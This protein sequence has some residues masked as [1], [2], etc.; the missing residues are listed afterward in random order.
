MIAGALAAI[1]YNYTS[2]FAPTLE[3]VA[4]Q[5][6]PLVPSS[7]TELKSTKSTKAKAKAQT[8]EKVVDPATEW[9]PDALLRTR[10]GKKNQGNGGN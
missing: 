6:K 4:E 9:I 7:I 5:A 8:E 10:K 1:V 2:L 3:S